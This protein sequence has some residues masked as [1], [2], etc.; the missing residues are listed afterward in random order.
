MSDQ[1]PSVFALVD[2]LVSRGLSPGD[3]L[4]V[5]REID[6]TFGLT[7]RSSGSSEKQREKWRLKKERQRARGANV[8]GGQS[9]SAITKEVTTNTRSKLKK[10][11]KSETT[12]PG[13]V[14]GDKPKRSKGD[15]L[16]DDWQ[17]ND[18]HYRFGETLG[19]SRSQVVSFADRMRDWAVANAHRQVARKSGVRGWNAAF[20]NWLDGASKRNGGS[21]GKTQS[22]LG[23]YSG[24][25]ARLRERIAAE[26]ADDGGPAAGPQPGHGR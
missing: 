2:L 4:G 23:G 1:A 12:S 21:N 25:G 9:D 19:F 26:G 5:A 14:P 24:V 13:D 10:E 11:R 15:L 18:E 6:E 22:T 7:A 3:A 17:P 16:P 8:P 20:R